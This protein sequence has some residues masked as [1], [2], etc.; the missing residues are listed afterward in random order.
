MKIRSLALLLAFSAAGFEIAQATTLSLPPAAN[1]SESG[2][3]QAAISAAK[4][5]T[6]NVAR[7]TVRER[8]TRKMKGVPLT[9]PI[10]VRTTEPSLPLLNRGATGLTLQFGTGGNAFPTQYQALLNDVFTSVQS[11]LDTYLGA[12]KL[13]GV[14]TVKN[15]DASIGDRD[16]VAGGI[17]VH[18]TGSNREILFPVYSDNGGF[19]NEVAAVNFVHTLVLA[20]LG[21][22][23]ILS[24]GWTEGLARAVTMRICRSTGALPALLDREQI[25]SVLSSTYDTGPT[26]DWN[27]QAALAGPQFIAENLRNQPL[28][29]GGSVGGL[30]LL[31]Y[32]MAGSAWQKVLTEYPLFANNFLQSYYA[33]PSL[34][35]SFSQVTAL[36]QSTIGGLGGSTIEGLSFDQWARK[37]FILN[38][39]LVPGLKLQVQPF[40]ITSGLAGSDFGVFAIQIHAFRTALNGDESLARETAYPIF[41]T[42]SFTRFFASAQDDRADIIQGYGSVV[43]NFTGGAF[44]NE[45]YR[46]VVD[47][48]VLDAIERVAL[49][50]GAIATTANPNP[51]NFYGTIEGISASSSVPLVVRVQY[52]STSQDI[53]VKNLAFGALI[54]DTAFQQSLPLTV[55]VFTNV[56]STLTEIYSRR[57]NKGPG[58]I[59]LRL[60]TDARSSFEL[61]L[62]GGINMIGI[63]ITPAEVDGA[64]IL[65]SNPLTTLLSRYAPA[66]SRFE[67][68]PECGTVR[69]GYG[70][71]TRQAA[72]STI[73]VPGTGASQV[74]PTVAL[75]QGWNLVS[76][77]LSRTVNKSELQLVVG[78]EIPVDYN[79]AVG[80]IIGTDVFE[81]V[82]GTPDSFSGV[83]ETG[84]YTS[85]SG[86]SEGN[87]F[88]IKVLSP[89]GATLV[90]PN[91]V[92]ANRP[93]VSAASAKWEM[94]LVLTGPGGRAE[95][96][97]GQAKGATRARES[98]FDIEAPPGSGGLSMIAGTGLFRD[99]HSF[100]SV[101]TFTVTLNGL[102][103]GGRYRLAMSPTARLSQYSVYDVA[104][105]QTTYFRGSKTYEFDASGPSMTLIINTMRPN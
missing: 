54:T 79:S 51:K 58:S 68:Y 34:Y 37:Q 84:N 1:R 93:V 83:P 9:F 100:G 85:V 5:F 97:L 88:W 40:P 90:F 12:P 7:L 35:A 52:G 30:Y 33:N 20:Y 44:N 43:P 73:T 92:A 60:I 49:P 50:A 57:V 65:G 105:R 70:F 63:L 2:M 72:A 23:E 15:Y 74:S 45:P 89:N 36:G 78:A 62:N 96:I 39:K 99:T 81:F 11:F 27:N 8:A 80:T 31:K 38:P 94:P 48:P 47:V 56:N 32:L 53:P 13:S 10:R 6:Q 24:D 3:E 102:T 4:K 67:F 61:N 19:K 76:N 26:Y 95:A 55:K 104:T 91:A 75:R 46:V 82:P 28:P 17:Y 22:S 77:M 18:G 103:P 42:P 16:A 14:V 86:I 71:F 87:A 64:A 25:D 101:D 98:A 41:W 21:N 69:A 29:V 66:D 59:G